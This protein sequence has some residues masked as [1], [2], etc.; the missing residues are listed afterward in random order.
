MSTFFGQLVGFAL[1]VFLVVR[2]AVPPVRGLMTARQ[3][4]VRQQLEDSATA[5]ERLTESTTAH[6]KAV[7]NAKSEADRV[8]E[9]AK[10]DAG[11][12][13]AQL[14]AQAEVESERIKGQGASQA[15]LLRTQLSRQL[16]QEL[17]LES[18]RQAGEL[19]RNFV[20]DAAQQS[21]TVD[22]FLDELDEMA[23]AAVSVEYPLMAKMRSASRQALASVSDRFDTIA[24]DLDANG[25]RTLAGE[26]VEVANLL[27][28]EIV[29]TRYLTLPA[30]DSEPRVRLIER[31]V[32]GKVGDAALDL[33]RTAV[34]QRWSAKA[35]LVDAIEHVSRQALLEVAERDDQVDDVEE[36]LFRFSRILDSQPRLATLLGDYSV[37]AD[38]RVG[39]LRNVLKSSG[40][41]V[42]PI[43][44]AL[45]SQTVELLRG[46]SAE[47]A[48][49]FLAEVAVARRG[50][51]VAQARAAADLSDA[52]RTRLTEVLS[53]IYGH[54]VTVQLEIDPAVLGGLSIAVGDEV[55]DG[56]LSS[57]LAAAEAQLPD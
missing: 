19:V 49:L 39:L 3:N 52:Q 29:L 56:T 50:E 45:L 43:A 14:Q 54:P 51:V 9:E 31:L 5:A 16:R 53:R 36:Q 47:E 17:G 13:S 48:V 20:A 1:I 12:I 55:I 24:K 15:A 46:Q 8:V 37:P 27:T 44:A 18:V 42:N 4:T 10:V 25:L 7:Q 38:G 57:R 6:S 30:E 28:R 11:R 33:L 40:G 35:D 32:A 2:Y 22:R 23:P 41:R 21:A 26:L 34:S